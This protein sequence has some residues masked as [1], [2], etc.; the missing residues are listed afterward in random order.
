MCPTTGSILVY[1]NF[2]QTVLTSRLRCSVFPERFVRHGSKE[3]LI[4]ESEFSNH[5][6]E[7]VTRILH[8]NAAPCRNL[9]TA[10]SLLEN[11]PRGLIG[12]AKPSHCRRTGRS[13]APRVA[14]SVPPVEHLAAS[15][16]GR[17][18]SRLAEI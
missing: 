2:V 6:S 12:S 4:G 17:R 14:Q 5:R 11:S 8:G 7:C 10:T 16:E 9:V 3:F 13:N 18:Q 1:S 15:Y